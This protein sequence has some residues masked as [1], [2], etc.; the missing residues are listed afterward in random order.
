V[1]A[2][3]HDELWITSEELEESNSNIVGLIEMIKA[4]Y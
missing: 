2:I 3:V 4:F 1:G